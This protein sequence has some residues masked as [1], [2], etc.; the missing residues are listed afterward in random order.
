MDAATTNRFQWHQDNNYGELDPYNAISC[1]TAL[2]D[3]DVENGCRGSFPAVTNKGKSA[4]VRRARPKPTRRRRDRGQ[5]D[6]S[7]A[8]PMPLKAGERPFS[9][10]AGRCTSPRAISPRIGSADSLHALRGCRRGG[11]LQRPV[12]SRLG[13]LVRGTTRFAEVQAFEADLG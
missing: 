2:D 12:R 5:A 9:F 4:S 10:T 13:R 1:L 7:K 8:V 6:E 11:G 3:A